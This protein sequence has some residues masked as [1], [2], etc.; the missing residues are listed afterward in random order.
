VAGPAAR[1]AAAARQRRRARGRRRVRRRGRRWHGRHAGWCSVR[2]MMCMRGPHG[3]AGVAWVQSEFEGSGFMMHA[4]VSSACTYRGRRERRCGEGRYGWCADLPGCQSLDFR[5]VSVG[6]RVA[7]TGGSCR[8]GAASSIRIRWVAVHLCVATDDLL[9]QCRG[10]T[11]GFTSAAWGR[12]GG[13]E[14]QS[15]S[16]CCSR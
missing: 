1:V 8:R 14:G 2:A 3:A 5:K 6:A 7:D 4:P 12:L 9:G 11:G 16:G 13:L 10:R 15:L